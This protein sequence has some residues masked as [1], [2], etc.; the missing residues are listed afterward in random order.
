MATAYGID[1]DPLRDIELDLSLDEDDI[2][3]FELFEVASGNAGDHFGWASRNFC[4]TWLAPI[5][6]KDHAGRLYNPGFTALTRIALV[7]RRNRGRR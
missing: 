5:I 1:V 2:D 6:R 4:Q 7:G 3:I